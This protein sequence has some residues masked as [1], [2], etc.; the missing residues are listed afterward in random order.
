MYKDLH[1]YIQFD[2]E[3]YIN[4]G[5][6]YFDYIKQMVEFAYMHKVSVFYSEKQ[7]KDFVSIISDLDNNF[8]QS[9]GNKLD[10]ILRNSLVKK[11]NKFIFNILFNYENTT[12]QHSQLLGITSNEQIAII[13]TNLNCFSNYLL[14]AKDE[15]KIELLRINIFNKCIDIVNWIH[16]ISP[17]NF[18]KSAKHGENGKG[19]WPGESCLLCSCQ[20]AQELLNTSIPDFGEKEG[21]LFNYDQENN[22]YIEFFYEGNNPQKQWHGFHL[23]QEDWQRVPTNIRTFFRV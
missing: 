9:I 17:R 16:K 12:I 5:D 19:N 21:R 18:N 1:F 13:S 20:D 22:T 14:Y 3:E 7:L 10:I 15:K 11:E 8:I 23:K 4:L 6:Q 2:W